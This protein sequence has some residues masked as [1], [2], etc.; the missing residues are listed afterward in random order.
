MFEKH[1]TSLTIASKLKKSIY[2]IILFITAD[3]DQDWNFKMGY[4]AFCNHIKANWRFIRIKDNNYS[5]K[6]Y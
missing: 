6:N 1:N 4:C 3:I 5:I 2:N